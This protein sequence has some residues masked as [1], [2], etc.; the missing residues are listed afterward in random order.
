MDWR[1]A[2]A[3]A[4]QS[5]TVETGAALVTTAIFW[6]LAMAAVASFI[7]LNKLAD[8]LCIGNNVLSDG[9]LPWPESCGETSRKEEGVVLLD[10]KK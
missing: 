5:V 10:L 1:A 7:E 4:V 6:R 3:V 2:A 9:L 8:K